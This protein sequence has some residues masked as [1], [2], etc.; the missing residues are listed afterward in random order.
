LQNKDAALATLIKASEYRQ[1]TQSLREMPPLDL[2]YR[3]EIYENMGDKEKAENSY[4]VFL[5]QMESYLNA[6]HDSNS[7]F[8]TSELLSLTRYQIDGIRLALG[9]KLKPLLPKLST[10]GRETSMAISYLSMLAPP[11]AR[12]GYSG[13]DSTVPDPISM[14]SKSTKDFGSM[15]LN[16]AVVVNSPAGSSDSVQEKAAMAYLAKYEDGYFAMV[17]RTMLI[18]NYKE[19]DE[20]AKAAALTEEVR[21]LAAK[22][23]MRV[24]LEGDPTFASPEITWETFKN[25]LKDGDIYSLASCYTPQGKRDAGKW[26]ELGKQNIEKLLDRLGELSQISGN[27]N[28]AFYEVKSTIPGEKSLFKLKFINIDG[29][30]KMDD[31]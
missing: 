17:L 3:G 13:I 2:L 14:I 9:K 11:M 12:Y 18:K 29:E 10:A 30:W 16:F 5:G 26:M 25:A 23:G 31:F 6:G 20:I 4:L 8:I 1:K 28:E 22:R 15:I 7:Y 19:N 24:L 27:T 21:N